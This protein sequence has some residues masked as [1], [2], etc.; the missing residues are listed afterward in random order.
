MNARIGPD[1]LRGLARSLRALDRRV[2]ASPLDKLAWLPLQ[3]K[4]LSHSDRRPYLYRAGQRQGKTTAGSAELIWRCLGQHP[5]KR[6]KIPTEKDPVKC[7]LIT[8]SG[9]QGVEIQKVLHDLIPPEVLLPGQVFSARTGYRGHRPVIEFKNG[10]SIVIYSNGQG[11]EALVGSEYDFILIDEPPDQEVYDEALARVRNTGGNVALTLTPIN[12]PPLPWLQKLCDDGQVVDY[13]SALTPESQVSP[14]TGQAR[15]TKDGRV[16]DATFIEYLREHT[17]RLIAPIT[18]DGE[19]ER[20]AEGQFFDA[21][22]PNRHITTHIPAKTM[23]WFLGIDFASADRDLGMC[24]VL[25]GAESYRDE[26]GRKQTRLYVYDEVV[27]SGKTSME[28][29]AEAILKCLQDRG[30]QWADLDGIYADNPIS[31][32]QQTKVLTS[33]KEL[34]KWIARFLGVNADYLRPRMLSAKEGIGGSNI[35]RRTKDLRCKWFGN[36]IGSDRVRVHPRCVTVIKALEQWDFGDR[37]P[38]K[39]VLDA[40]MYGIKPLWRDPAQWAGDNYKP[41]AGKTGP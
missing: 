7:A 13:H 28:H 20:R 29:F 10:S 1:P 37:H 24:A 9:A 34:S 2:Q 14:L 11:P 17:N 32:G 30:L 4:W 41:V 12:G 23:E 15:R 6:V 8:L 26:A 18:L 16:W 22:D 39:D 19:W 5:F 27:R 33:K 25:T 3:I 40:T 36:E 21:F 38:L 35:T 31:T